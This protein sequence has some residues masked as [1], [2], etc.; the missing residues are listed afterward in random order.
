MTR[1]S[2]GVEEMK[3]PPFVKLRRSDPQYEAA[4]REHFQGTYQSPWN[5][6]VWAARSNLIHAAVETSRLMDIYSRAVERGQ[7]P[8]ETLVVTNYNY[9]S[10]LAGPLL[11]TILAASGALEAL[12]RMAMRAFLEKDLPKERRAEGTPEEALQSLAEFDALTA[13]A[14]LDYLYMSLLNRQ[15]QDAPRA[16]FKHL[17]EFRNNCFHADP[18]L[19]LG[20][21]GDETTKGGKRRP[22]PLR[23]G[24]P[25]EYPLLWAGN[26]PLS[27]THALRAIGVHD[28]IV[29]ELLGEPIF[30]H[31]RNILEVGDD[32]RMHLIEGFL[33]K[34]ISPEV[35]QR[36]AQVWDNVVERGLANVSDDDQRLYLL[37]LSREVTIRSVK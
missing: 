28:S 9:S 23:R 36:L 14:K 24:T 5:F 33:P 19:R 20:T 37:E 29:R 21:G 35:L 32:S 4:V 10:Q 7:R 27:L 17:A 12:L 22:V 31:L 1:L 13:L 18:V 2:G 16:E 15:C 25:P 30:G 11:G 6:L 8:A 26:R 3:L 34:P